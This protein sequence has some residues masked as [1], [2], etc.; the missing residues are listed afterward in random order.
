MKDDDRES[1]RRPVQRATADW[2]LRNI[3]GDGVAVSGGDFPS[4]QEVGAGPPFFSLGTEVG[5]H[6]GEDIRSCDRRSDF[7]DCGSQQK[8]PVC[9]TRGEQ[10]STDTMT[11][12]GAK[13]KGGAMRPTRKRNMLRAGCSPLECLPSGCLFTL[14][15]FFDVSRIADFRLLSSTLKAAVDSPGSLVECSAFT[16][17]SKLASTSRTPERKELSCSDR[18]FSC[19]SSFWWGLLDR[20]PHLRRLAICRDAIGAF[21]G[22]E[23]TCIP[24][25][26]SLRF[27][28]LLLRRNAAVLETLKI[29]SPDLQCHRL[30]GRTEKTPQPTSVHARRCEQQLRRR[31]TADGST[32]KPAR[33]TKAHTGP[34][35]A[36]GDASGKGATEATEAEGGRLLEDTSERGAD[37]ERESCS[38]GERNDC[39]WATSRISQASLPVRECGQVAGVQHE[40][41]PMG[42]T[43]NRVEALQPGEEYFNSSS[44][45]MVAPSKPHLAPSWLPFGWHP[46]SP[47]SRNFVS[48]ARVPPFASFMPHASVSSLVEPTSPLYS[49][50]DIIH[51]TLVF[52]RL[53]S[54]SLLGCHSFLWLRLLSKCSFPSCQ[55]FS[56]VCQCL[57]VHV[58]LAGEARSEGDLCQPLP[59]SRQ[60]FGGGGERTGAARN[61][62]SIE[63]DIVNLLLSAP[64]LRFLR[65][66]TRL[67]VS[68][69]V[70]RAVFGGFY[71]T[72]YDEERRFPGLTH[73]TD[74][75]IGDRSILHVADVVHEIVNSPSRVT[76][77]LRQPVSESLPPDEPV[78][79][80][81]VP[82]PSE[83]VTE[84]QAEP[85]RASDE[86]GDPQLFLS[87]DAPLSPP[88]SDPQTDRTGLTHDAATH[89]VCQLRR[90]YLGSL[91]GSQGEVPSVA[92]ASLDVLMRAFPD[93]HFV[94]DTFLAGCEGPTG[95]VVGQ[96]G[97]ISDDEE[98]ARLLP[99]VLPYVRH[100]RLH[101]DDP[102]SDVPLVPRNTR[103]YETSDTARIAA[104]ENRAPS[105]TWLS[106][107]PPS[108]AP[109]ARRISVDFLHFHPER[110]QGL[111]HCKFGAGAPCPPEC[112]Q[113]LGR[114]PP[115]S[116][117]THER[118]AWEVQQRRAPWPSFC[119]E[120][121][122]EPA[123][124]P[125]AR[126]RRSFSRASSGNCESSGASRLRERCKRQA[127][128]DASSSNEP[129]VPAGAAPEWEV[130]VPRAF[131]SCSDEATEGHEK[132]S[133]LAETLVLPV[134]R[135]DAFPAF[136][137]TPQRPPRLL[138]F[139]TSRKRRSRLRLR[140]TQGADWR[141]AEEGRYNGGSSPRRADEHV[142]R[143]GSQENSGREDRRAAGLPG[144]ARR[145]RLERGRGWGQGEV[146]GF[147]GGARSV[148]ARCRRTRERI[149]I[150]LLHALCKDP[151][152]RDKVKGLE[153][154]LDELVESPRT[155]AFVR[156][157]VD[158]RKKKERNECRRSSLGRASVQTE[159][160]LGDHH[161]EESAMEGDMH[162]VG[163]GR[164]VTFVDTGRRS[165]AVWKS[166]GVRDSAM[167]LR[168][169]RNDGDAVEISES[170]CLEVLRLTNH[171]LGPDEFP[172]G[173][174][175]ITPPAIQANEQNGRKSDC[176]AYR[177]RSVEELGVCAK[178]L[179]SFNS[180]QPAS[181]PSER[182]EGEKIAAL[183]SELL[184]W[185]PELETIEV[186]VPPFLFDEEED[187]AWREEPPQL[188]AVEKLLRSLGFVRSTVETPGASVYEHVIVF[189]R[190]ENIWGAAET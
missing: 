22:G 131:H 25:S 79:S 141:M 187:E 75:A 181:V 156:A 159:R 73:L 91:G 152:L 1:P 15:S 36:Q 81:A 143:T 70:W 166:C 157:L 14:F 142:G 56:L 21:E 18:R 175:S 87:R 96:G 61:T 183:F 8:A 172:G 38:D 104:R 68:R 30:V 123:C 55:V 139:A 80:S 84:S 62:M 126:P 50:Y 130:G 27:L 5:A 161:G 72:P 190:R 37:S 127:G 125:P 105:L 32:R 74:L 24:L 99:R 16:V 78:P 178:L 147:L 33:R 63:G 174:Y 160:E 59:A 138:G 128:A 111:F 170:P 136:L 86:T 167:D 69:R 12:R 7:V 89:S 180:S 10:Q 106:S 71:S 113:S 112:D 188:V 168:D 129:R 4:L 101:F 146:C 51:L 6:E 94:L 9:P 90:V 115:S 13:R 148:L 184:H 158:L 49:P 20:P 54:L 179:G 102:N 118:M 26:S 119:I 93:C 164:S 60:C 45:W 43:G 92:I 52:P 185:Y 109:H 145:E 39:G 153:L 108:V 29:T 162:R 171:C 182:L 169:G 135:S 40:P 189:E 110:H 186:E 134:L 64:L 116:S 57:G 44:S 65:L 103:F 137:L 163:L 23:R 82:S 58:A 177:P 31:V 46:L 2:G 98:V 47:A 3:P 173:A 76:I 17:T 85:H 132:L 151:A 66:E 28:L 48:S 107:S 100:L 121:L 165:L 155:A 140:E 97:P 83:T 133:A 117:S 11:R 144:R 41:L 150:D 77:A 53:S 88:T 122:P 176:F 42:N 149:D 19:A 34:P 124:S 154:H 114:R 120:G 35:Y 95:D 67:P